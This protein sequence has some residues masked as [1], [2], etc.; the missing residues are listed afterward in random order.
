VLS[1][2]Y[3][4]TS[5]LGTTKGK[6]EY[7]MINMD[8]ELTFGISGNTPHLQ[9]KESKISL[10]SSKMVATEGNLMKLIAFFFNSFSKLISFIINKYPSMINSAL[11][12]ISL[13]FSL[14]LTGTNIVANAGI[15][16]PLLFE[17]GYTSMFF[18]MSF[19]NSKTKES[20]KDEVM[21]DYKTPVMDYSRNL[22][23]II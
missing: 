4:Y 10:G 3:E 1:Y 5:F 9:I 17:K 12:M 11:E 7:H 8:I 15:P 19:T 2:D 21:H 6:G 16:M 18:D 22:Y 23:V 14:P 20:F 13:Q